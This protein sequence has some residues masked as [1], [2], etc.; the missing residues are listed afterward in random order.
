[1]GDGNTGPPAGC[2]TA[3]LT[4]PLSTDRALQRILKLAFYDAGTAARG[5]R[6]PLGGADRGAAG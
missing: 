4:D 3:E 5:R 1:M 2:R 6:A